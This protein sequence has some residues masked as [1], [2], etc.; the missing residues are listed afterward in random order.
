MQYPVLKPKFKFIKNIDPL[1]HIQ[2]KYNIIKHDSK[3]NSVII[4]GRKYTT[5]YSAKQ[6]SRIYKC[7]EPDPNKKITVGIISLGG[8]LVGNVIKNVYLPNG[9]IDTNSGTLTYG[10]IQSYWKW[11]G[12]DSNSWPRVIIKSIDGTVNSPSKNEYTD[13]YSATIE[14][15]IDIETIGSWCSSSNLT[16]I[17][18]LTNNSSLYNALSYAINSNVVTSTDT[19][20]PSVISITWGAPES[21][22]DPIYINA[23]NNLCSN[24]TNK[25]INICVAT[26]DKCLKDNISTFTTIDFPSSSEWVTSCGG[27]SLVCPG[28]VYTKSTVETIWNNTSNKYI[29]NSGTSIYIPRPLYQLSIPDNGLN[30]YVPDISF[31]SD[32]YTGMVYYI[33]GTFIE[34]IGGTSIAATSMAGFLA[35]INISTFINPLIYSM[36]FNCFNYTKSSIN[37]SNVYTGR[38]SINCKAFTSSIFMENNTSNSP[39]ILARPYFIC[40]SNNVNHLKNSIRQWFDCKE[41]ATIYK[42][43]SP[44]TNSNTIG[45]ISLGGGLFGNFNTTTGILTNGDIQQY[46][47]SI[48]IS[49][50]NHPRVIIKTLGSSVNTPSSNTNDTRNYS[51]TIENTVDIETIGSWYPSSKLT[52][53]M[54][55]ANQYDDNYAF[56]NALRYSIN[57]NVVIGTTTYNKPSTISISWGFPEIYNSSL[58]NAM[59]TQFSLAEQRGINIFCASGDYG[60]TDGVSGFGNITDF[61][62]CSPSVIACGG[63]SLVCPN[64]VYDS[65]TVE[66][67]WTNGG[68]GMSKIFS[69][70]LYQYKVTQSTSNRCSPDISLNANPDTGVMYRIFG[71]DVIV[72]GTSIVSPAAAAFI[73]MLN[74]KFF[75]NTKLYSLNKTA[76]HDIVS[77]NNGGYNARAGYDLC[78]GLGSLNGLKFINL[79]KPVETKS[80]SISPGNSIIQKDSTLQLTATILPTNATNKKIVWSSSKSKIVSISSTGLCTAKL[81]GQCIITAKQGTIKNTIR[82]TVTL[83]LVSKNIVIEKNKSCII[84]LNNNIDNYILKNNSEDIV[85]CDYNNNAWKITGKTIGEAS[86]IIEYLDKD[87]AGILNV[88]VV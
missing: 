66:S 60:S 82:I 26:G 36:D 85:D 18:Y 20:T 69:K 81:P 39:T 50:S 49:E 44:P 86:L 22:F 30:R 84:K 46:W 53:I 38:G 9:E 27:T 75:L 72:G 29:T 43:P 15:T 48:G 28:N 58:I 10:D 17:M 13:N 21:L 37:D 56:F 1:N 35:S 78:S 51:A 2:N 76:F 70:P 73:S 12:I 61:P 8:G 57:S 62:S 25:G 33:N 87:E 45:V 23:F 14:N 79:L 4:N 68:G 6:L 7:P 67:A 65:S 19:Y 52:I 54:Y 31:N 80:I 59:Q 88:S 83:N 34:R 11:Q 41:M 16:I 55:L 3:L 77:G 40:N 24:A 42:C 71:N 5:D 47:T 74:L 32:P 64:Y 63:T